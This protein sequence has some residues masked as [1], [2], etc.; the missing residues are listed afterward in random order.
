MQTKGTRQYIE[1]SRTTS[2]VS[3]LEANPLM[4]LIRMMHQ[5][6]CNLAIKSLQQTMVD[7]ENCM[8]CQ[9]EIEQGAMNPELL[10]FFSVWR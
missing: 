5:S 4:L 8:M 10:R 3:K 6:F 2:S 1:K 9:K 7:K